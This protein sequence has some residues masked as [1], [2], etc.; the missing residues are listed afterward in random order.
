MKGRAGRKDT[1][2]CSGAREARPQP[3]REDG[4]EAASTHTW[5]KRLLMATHCW[6]PKTLVPKY[7]TT[8]SKD[9]S[10]GAE[11]HSLK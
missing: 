2:V 11:W 4:A 1:E 6:D 8:V 5:E 7:P 10:Q 9:R 3:R